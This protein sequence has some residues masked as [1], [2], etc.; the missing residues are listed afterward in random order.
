MDKIFNKEAFAKENILISKEEAHLFSKYREMLVEW[1]KKVNLTSI[2]EGK[3]VLYKHFIDSLLLMQ[4]PEIEL[5]NKSIIDVGTGA[6]FPGLPL[7]I[8]NE[9]LKVTLSDS[10]KKRTDFLR[11]AV[12]EMELKNVEIIEGR[13]ED[14]GQDKTYREMYDYAVA[15]AVSKLPVLLEYTLP[16]VKQGGFFIAYK[17]PDYL[18]ELEESKE[19]LAELGGQVFLIKNFKFNEVE[20]ER[21]I[22]IFKKNKNTPQKYPRR[23]GIPLKRP[24]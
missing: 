14:L 8:I 2:L 12:N 18:S 20:I 19:A 1:N 21:N 5:S 15:R 23:A 24:L 6:G 3:E 7:A 13:A 4:I 17:G 22:I 9:K 11:Y 16:F 10:L